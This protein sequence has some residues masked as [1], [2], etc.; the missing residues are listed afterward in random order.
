M[1]FEKDNFLEFLAFF[2]CAVGGLDSSGWMLV[3]EDH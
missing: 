3:D 1:F 2:W